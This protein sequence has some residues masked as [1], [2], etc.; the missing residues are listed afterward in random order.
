MNVEPSA[1]VLAAR[2]DWSFG[3]TLAHAFSLRATPNELEEWVAKLDCCDRSQP[4]GRVSD[5]HPGRARQD[6][7][8]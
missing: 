8:R 2:S 1:V 7:L 4:G 5:V 6:R 3:M